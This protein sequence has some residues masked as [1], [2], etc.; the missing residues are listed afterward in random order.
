MRQGDV[1]RGRRCCP[2]PVTASF[3]ASIAGLL[4]AGCAA[5]ADLADSRT[6]GR[7]LSLQH[8]IPAERKV[9]YYQVDR[10]GVFGTSGGIDA[11]TGRV[12]WSTV[13]DDAELSALLDPPSA[14]AWWRELDRECE[15]L[16]RG[17]AKDA[18]R[19]VIRFAGPTIDRQRSFRGRPAAIVPLLDRMQRLSMGRFVDTLDALP[20]AGERFPN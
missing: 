14:E 10:E 2:S 6:A 18:P 3:A 9:G 20:R 13:L 16:E 12:T 8:W 7:E 17:L 5:T 1:R 4:L 11:E 15:A 19:T